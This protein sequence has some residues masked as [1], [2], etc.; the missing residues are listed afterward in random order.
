V[1]FFCELSLTLGYSCT[2]GCHRL[3]A[4]NVVITGRQYSIQFVF[5]LTSVP[6][7]PGAV[8]LYSVLQYTIVLQYYRIDLSHCENN[9]CNISTL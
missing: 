6:S 7:T 8:T 4:I 9:L 1:L 2:I 5:R 3:F